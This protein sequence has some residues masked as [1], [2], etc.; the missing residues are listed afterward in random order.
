MFF[1]FFFQLWVWLGSNFVFLCSVV[2][3]NI[4]MLGV[5]WFAFI[6]IFITN[7]LSHLLNVLPMHNS[8]CNYTM[9]LEE[10]PFGFVFNA[11]FFFQSITLVAAL[12]YFVT[13]QCR[14]FLLLLLLFHFVYIL[15]KWSLSMYSCFSFPWIYIM[16]LA[17]LIKLNIQ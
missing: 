10:Q 17:V 8:T 1:F 2:H 5:Y 3:L 13:Y 9:E 14:C 16:S 6:A 7:V 4:N 15:F 11:G 12:T